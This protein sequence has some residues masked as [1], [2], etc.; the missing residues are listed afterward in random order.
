MSSSLPPRYVGPERIY[1]GGMADIYSALDRQ[2]GRKVAI[3]ILAERFAGDEDHRAWLR[4]EAMAVARLSHMLE[5]VRVY[6]V[7]EWQ[8]RPYLAMEYLGGGS[9]ASRLRRGQISGE[10]A[11]RWLRQA[12]MAIDAVHELGM[13][14]RD[15]T[16]HNLVLDVHDNVRLTDFGIASALDGKGTAVQAQDVIQGTGGFIAPEHLAGDPATPASDVFGLGAVANALLTAAPDVNH[17]APELEAVLSRALADRPVDRFATA[18]EFVRELVLVLAPDMASTHVFHETATDTFP[19]PTK[20]F[21]G[22]PRREP[23]RAIQWSSLL[24]I[25][26]AERAVRAALLIGIGVTAIVLRD[27]PVSING[28]VVRLDHD[29]S[30][31]QNAYDLLIGRTLAATPHD[32]LVLGALALAFGALYAVESVGLLLRIQAAVY[33]TIATTAALIPV[34]IWE[35]MHHPSRLKEISLAVNVAVALSL[36]GALVRAKIAARRAPHPAVAQRAT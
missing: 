4:R 22:A 24:P 19:M 5:V 36:S 2:L 34:E 8:G 16:L 10:L 1:R 6:D 20:V 28:K 27:N 29:L 32:L 17:R 30:P 3:K 21:P 26:A 12:A 18:R 31:S 35:I 7:G 11:I 13:V 14:H 33:L 15:V 9:L 23:K 25:A